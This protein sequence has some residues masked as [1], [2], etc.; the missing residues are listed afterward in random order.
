MEP[1]SLSFTRLTLDDAAGGPAFAEVA[2]LNGDGKLDLVVSKF[3]VIQM[4]DLPMGQVTIYYQGESLNEWTAEPLFGDTIGI[5]WPNDITLE[6]LDDDGDLDAIVGAGFLA[7]EFVPAVGPCG[8][9]FWFENTSSGWVQHDIISTGSELFYHRGVLADLDG[10]GIEDLIA[11]GERRPAPAS[12]IAERAEA[13]WFKGTDDWKRFESTPHV[14]A[15]GLGGL[16]TVVDLT[17]DGL[18]DIASAEFFAGKGAS[19]VW[20]EQRAAPSADNPA[21]LW[22]RHIIDD[23]VGPAIQLSFIDDLMGDGKPGVVGSVHTNTAKDPA[24]PWGSAVYRYEIPDNP[25]QPWLRTKISQHILSVAGLPTSPQAAPG[26]FGWGD[27]DG[28]ADLDLLVSGDGDPRVYLL[29]QE[30]GDFQTWVLDED[31]T[32]AGSMKIEDLDGDGKTEFVVSGYDANVIYIYTWD[33][34]GTYPLGI[35]EPRETGVTPDEDLPQPGDL[36]VNIDYAGEESGDVIVALFD[37]LPPAGP[38]SGFQMVTTDRFP[39]SV[40]F[41]ALEG[42]TYQALAFLDLEPFNM[43]MPDV[44]DPQVSSDPFKVDGEPISISLTLE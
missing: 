1:Y 12:G 15:D 9:L 22:E 11:V 14:I 7:C 41:E 43:T 25:R 42:G 24:D 3:G 28:D 8:G 32:Q 5:Y 30:A 20:Y 2:D 26:I 6:D 17:G 37:S 44:T 16:P 33:E 34:E 40:T 39:V 21:G 13:Q 31:M 10:D 19:F 38:P 23:E 27:A 4:P 36:T 18:V 35:A 29:V